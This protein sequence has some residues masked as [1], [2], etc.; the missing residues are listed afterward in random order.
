MKFYEVMTRFD[1]LRNLENPVGRRPVYVVK[2]ADCSPYVK[3]NGNIKGNFRFFLIHTF[4]FNLSYCNGF[5][6]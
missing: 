2:C 6:I 4:E 5:E 3:S 1:E